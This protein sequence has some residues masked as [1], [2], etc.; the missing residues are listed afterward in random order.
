[1]PKR[2]NVPCRLCGKPSGTTQERDS[3]AKVIATC[4]SCRD[5]EENAQRAN[6]RTTLHFNKTLGQPHEHRK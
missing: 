2:I 1:M 3:K 4:K 6:I 5:W